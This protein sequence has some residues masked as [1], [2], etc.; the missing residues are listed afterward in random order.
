MSKFEVGEIVH[1]RR[2]DYRGVIIARDVVCRAPDDWYR[3]NQTQPSR[4]QPWY[5]VLVD[6]GRETYVAHEN[7][8]VAT[9]NG[10]VIHPLVDKFF[11]AFFDGRYYLDSLN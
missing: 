11:P 9:E 4:T 6:G 3:G 2:Y 1:H 5:R 7:L 8:E 10:P